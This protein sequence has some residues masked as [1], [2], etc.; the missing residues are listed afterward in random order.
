MHELPQR[1]LVHSRHTNDS[2]RLEMGLRM[3]RLTVN[4]QP[5]LHNKPLVRGWFVEELGNYTIE[6]SGEQAPKVNKGLHEHSFLAGVGGRQTAESDECTA[7]RP[8]FA[9]GTRACPWP[10][11]LSCFRELRPVLLLLGTRFNKM[12]T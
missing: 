11:L 10:P 8:R 7:R 6:A 9:N 12:T 2:Q 1:S 5:L 3:P 4:H